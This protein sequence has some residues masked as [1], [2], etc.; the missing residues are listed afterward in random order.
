MNKMAKCGIQKY[1][2]CTHKHDANECKTCILIK[3]RTNP[4]KWINGQKYKKC[5]HCEEYKPLSEF[6]TNS[7]GYRSWCKD[8]NRTYSRLYKRSNN[9]TFV[10]SYKENNKKKFEYIKSLPKTIKFVKEYITNNTGPI[11]IKKIN[12]N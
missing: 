5:P 4:Y 1:S 6:K 8:C 3:R 9:Q 10:I 2:F 11:E 7:E 12:N